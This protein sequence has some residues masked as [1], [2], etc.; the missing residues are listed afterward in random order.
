MEKDH[1]TM[2]DNFIFDIYKITT[3]PIVK[4]SKSDHDEETGYIEIKIPKLLNF[5]LRK[6]RLENGL[7]NYFYIDVLSPS[8]YIKTFTQP[9]T[10]GKSIDY[11]NDN[12]TLRLLD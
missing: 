5:Q 12:L 6:Y 7:N 8:G 11:T 9:R 2:F 1:K 10:S 3:T 4:F